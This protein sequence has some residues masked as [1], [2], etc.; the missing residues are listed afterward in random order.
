MKK[1]LLKVVNLLL[2]LDFLMLISTAIIRK[3]LIPEGLYF[4]LHGIPGFVFAG[5]VL[6]HIILNF[7]WIKANYIKH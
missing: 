1:K 5:L 6:C 2:A 3:V 4:N 7:S